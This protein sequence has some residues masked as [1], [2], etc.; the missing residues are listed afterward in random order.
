[1]V[2]QEVNLAPNLS[3]AQNL[4]LG[5]QPTRFG[6]VR[7]GEMRRR[8]RALLAE[9]DIAIDVA[10]PL[11]SYSVAIQHIVAIARAV[12]LSARVLILDEPT[13]SL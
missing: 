5:R 9:F 4:F 11:G 1:T 12:D 7:E 8:A 13:A 2:Y 3:V 10:A 6:F